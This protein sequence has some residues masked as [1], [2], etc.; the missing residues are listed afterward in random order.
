MSTS[1][2]A[3][4]STALNALLAGTASTNASK[5]RRK[6]T[7]KKRNTTAATAVDI[8]DLDPA[9]RAQMEAEEKQRIEDAVLELKRSAKVKKEEALVRERVRLFCR[10]DGGKES[11]MCCADLGDAGREVWKEEWKKEESD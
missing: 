6:K 3:A 11:L 9:T 1:T 7:S 5:P 2:L 4:A 10:A 8:A